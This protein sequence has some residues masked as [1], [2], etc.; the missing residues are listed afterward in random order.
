MATFIVWSN[1][2]VEKCGVRLGHFDIPER[3]K[4]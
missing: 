2:T 3:N 4:G 1:G